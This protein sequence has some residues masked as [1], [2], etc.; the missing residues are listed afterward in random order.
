MTESRVEKM[1]TVSS[2]YEQDKLHAWDKNESESE[3]EPQQESRL[4]SIFG[5]NTLVRNLLNLMKTGFK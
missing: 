2:L 5:K 3:L 4:S 1:K